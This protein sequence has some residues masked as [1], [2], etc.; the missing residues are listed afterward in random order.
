VGL[1]RS[2]AARRTLALLESRLAAIGLA[3]SAGT[4]QGQ[5]PALTG[6]F[7]DARER[8]SAS[9]PAHEDNWPRQEKAR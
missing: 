8:Q 9:R 5:I 1:G 2:D 6:R 3:P 7:G 4:A